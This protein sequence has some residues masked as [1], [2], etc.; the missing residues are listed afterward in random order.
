M[1]PFVHVDNK[2]IFFLILGDGPTQGLEYTLTARKT[3]SINFTVTKNNSFFE[4]AI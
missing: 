4:L 2:K 3:F 1:S